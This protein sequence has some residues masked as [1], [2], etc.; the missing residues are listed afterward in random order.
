MA[1]KK[2]TGWDELDP[3]AYIGLEKIDMSQAEPEMGIADFLL[4]LAPAIKT[5]AEPTTAGGLTA[6]DFAGLGDVSTKD[7]DYSNIVTGDIGGGGQV[8]PMDAP[9][10][11]LDQSSGSVGDI[12][13]TNQLG[14]GGIAIAQDFGP[15]GG[16]S[17][18][19]IGSAF[20]GA[21]GIDELLPDGKS[22]GKSGGLGSLAR[23]FS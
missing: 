11:G 21:R 14:S 22:K 18:V 9:V 5:L 12:M 1:K 13:G 16:L 17:N 23:M 10:F 6:K 8:N 4:Q 15:T 2:K 19:N 7:S 20:D 3:N